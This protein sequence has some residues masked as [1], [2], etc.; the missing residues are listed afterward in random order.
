MA[1]R[2]W[3]EQ[4]KAL[5]R[6]VAEQLTLGETKDEIKEQ[7]KEEIRLVD[8]YQTD[9]QEV[10]DNLQSQTNFEAETSDTQ[11]EKD[12]ARYMTG[13]S[14]HVSPYSFDKDNQ[15]MH[16][17]NA[18]EIGCILME[19]GAKLSEAALAFEA[20]VQEDPG[21]VDA[22]LKLGLVQTQN[23]KELNGISAVSYTHL[24]VYK[25]QGFQYMV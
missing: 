16:N 18:Y 13:K 25:R 4:F 2:N 11:W 21:H 22:W 8:D 20:A 9:F 7:N 6:E 10:W 17:P 19:N 5:E 15:Y 24:D 3:D 23:E 1:E 12:Y 14:T